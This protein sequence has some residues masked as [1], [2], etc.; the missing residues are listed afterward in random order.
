MLAWSQEV[1]TYFMH[2]EHVCGLQ[3]GP[4]CVWSVADLIADVAARLAQRDQED[5]HIKRKLRGR[6]E[7]T[8]LDPCRL[9]LDFTLAA[10]S[11][12]GTL[13]PLMFSGLARGLPC[14]D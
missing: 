4:L 14:T 11:G 2:D 7:G 5:V 13:L 12:P 10:G 8:V 1:L 3:T 9:A 6:R